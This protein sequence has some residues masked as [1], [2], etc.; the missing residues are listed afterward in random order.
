MGE[1]PKEFLK[2]FR[3]QHIHPTLNDIDYVKY[4]PFNLDRGPYKS[5]DHYLN[6]Q[7]HLLREDFIYPLRK[8][9]QYYR[10]N[11]TTDNTNLFCSHVL[12]DGSRSF[13]GNKLGFVFKFEP[14][15]YNIHLFINGFLLLFS[16]DDFNT[17][18]VG[19]VL[20]DDIEYLKKGILLVE[21]LGDIDIRPNSIISMAQC[22]QF[23]VSYNWTLKALQ[24]MNTHTFPL[25]EYIVFASN[26][27]FPPDYLNDSSFQKYNIDDFTF[28]ILK[29]E[30]WPTETYLQQENN[31]Y[32]A[33]KAAL[34]Q[35]FV[36]I[37]G[38]PGT[39]K[40][41]IGQRVVKAMVENLYTTKKLKN[42]IAVICYNNHTLDHFLEGVLKIT[43]KLVRIGSQSKCEAL[44]KHS[45]KEIVKLNKLNIDKVLEQNLKSKEQ[46][47]LECYE[48]CDKLYTGILNWNILKSIVPEAF[49]LFVD[50][51][52]FLNWLFHPYPI[53]KML[54]NNKLCN[55]Q[56]TQHCLVIDDIKQRLSELT[57]QVTEGSEYHSLKVKQELT[58]LKKFHEYFEYMLTFDSPDVNPVVVDNIHLI[59]AIQRWVLYYSWVNKIVNNY[60]NN[61]TPI[62]CEYNKLCKKYDENR[63]A[64]TM[65]LLD[66]IYVIGLTTTGAVKNKDLLEQ[67]KPPIGKLLC[68][69]ILVLHEKK[70]FK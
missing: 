12:F 28:N 5:E 64:Q 39:G 63:L 16:K 22:E 13:F 50:C 66:G 27:S 24:Q 48:K 17:F 49:N 15:S 1:F 8:A 38:V 53:D 3:T 51:W 69:V 62:W 7:F 40:T 34:T 58:M 55:I 46:T 59:P 10:K 67:L 43:E 9:I 30:E 44:K 2:T 32:K 26:K 6:T 56:S 25:K 52:D 36:T 21:M 14:S 45:L 42:P 57:E 47:I 70:I 68:I 29:D 35:K 65:S 61:I 60:K 4:L 20:K 37:Q 31:Q 23:Y 19:L 11:K 41:F 33:F 54:K 18:F